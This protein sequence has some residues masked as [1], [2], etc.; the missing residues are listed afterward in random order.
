MTSHNN[1]LEQVRSGIEHAAWP[2]FPTG[3]SATLVSLLYQLEQSQWWPRDQIIR[4]QH[5]QLAVLTEYAYAFSPHLRARMQHAGLKAMDMVSPDKLRRLP[6]LTR[7]D[8]QK[9]GKGLYCSEV[10][11][12]HLPATELKTSGSTGE[13]VVVRKTALNNT[14]WLAITLREHFWHGRDFSN[15][16]LVIRANIP[17]PIEQ[18]DWG[19]PVNALFRSGPMRVISTACD[20]REQLAHVREFKPNQILAYPS[21]LAGMIAECEKQNI[22]IDGLSHIWT[23]GETLSPDLRQ[24]AE[25]FF[26]APIEDNYS[27]QEMGIIAIQ[28]PVSRMYHIMS[29]NVIVEIVDNNGE[30]CKE[31]QTGKVLVT[32]LHNFATPLV[33]YEIG[34]CAEAGGPC[35]CGRGL[36]T[37]KTIK[38]RTR[39]LVV[40]PDGSR[41]WPLVGFHKF[42][43]IA[44]VLQ[45]QFIQHS[46]ERIEVRLVVENP[47]NKTQEEALRNQIREALGHAFAIEFTYFPDRLPRGANDKFEEFICRI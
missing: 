27:S 47:L 19:A 22:R 38:G 15:R 6:P 34:D 21:N 23:I 39:N 14:F 9:A 13:P 28:C 40:K 18:D 37:L 36:P 11:R 33:R 43:D 8:I 26:R 25:T 29:E 35:P 44:P 5:E 32:D 16:L 10:P 45:F 1:R 46:L 31:G 12:S 4:K 2:P 20:I 41:H 3:P 30:P 17:K 7:R 24:R 42:R